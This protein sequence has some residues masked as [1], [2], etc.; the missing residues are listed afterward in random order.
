MSLTEK[1]GTLPSVEKKDENKDHDDDKEDED[2]KIL[3]EME[4]LT[5]AMDR[6]KKHEKK[7]LA[8]RKAKVSRLRTFNFNYMWSSFY[9]YL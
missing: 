6:K 2:D 3:N 1:D 8:K 7:R 5:Y 9:A 4:E